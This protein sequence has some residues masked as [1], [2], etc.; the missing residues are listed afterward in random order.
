[1]TP[2]SALSS[3]VIS[4]S[5][6]LVYDP[7]LQGEEMDF[8]NVDFAE[9]GHSSYYQLPTPVDH[10]NGSSPDVTQL[11]L[12]L[13][14]ND[15]RIEVFSVSDLNAASYSWPSSTMVIEKPL[16]PSLDKRFER[17]TPVVGI[18]RQCQPYFEIV[19]KHIMIIDQQEF[20]QSIISVEKHQCMALKHAVAMSGSNACGESELAMESYLA[21]RFHLE[22]AENLADSS[23]FLNIETVQALILVARFECTH[24]SGPKALL[25]IARLMQLIGLLGYDRLDQSSPE[26]DDDSSHILVPNPHSSGSLQ[27]IRQTYWVAFSIHCNAAASF[28]SCLPVK[29]KD[30][31]TTMPAPNSAIDSAADQVVYLPEEI[32]A[33]TASRLSVFSLFII[34]MKLVVCGDRHRQMT[35]KYV[36]DA[37]SDYNFCIVHEKIRGQASIAFNSLSTPEFLDRPDPELRVLT[38]IVILGV[39]IDW[40][41]TAIIGSRKAEFLTSAAR[42]Y[43]NSALAVA[44]AMCDLVLQADITDAKQVMCPQMILSFREVGEHNGLTH[45]YLYLPNIRERTLT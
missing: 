16:D 2:C 21:A 24:V 15:P 35:K 7:V 34:A 31:F 4:K 44:N 33:S 38:F 1:M 25:T 26:D 23:S 3:S 41:K 32:T 9:F 45:E 18:E 20:L 22:R 19:R 5:S 17:A 36:S 39:R 6:Q 14:M 27:K 42:E 43:R 37:A 10:A 13:N 12:D 8:S 29:D 40:Y 28:P 11:E 30:I